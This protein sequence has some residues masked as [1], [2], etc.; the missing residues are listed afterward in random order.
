MGKRWFDGGGIGFGLHVQLKVRAGLT[1]T[2][3]GVDSLMYPI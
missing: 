1:D 2:L 3:R